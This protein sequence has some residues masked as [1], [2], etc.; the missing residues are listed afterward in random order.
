MPIDSFFPTNV[1]EAMK[2]LSR[3]ISLALGC[4]ALSLWSACET[5]PTTADAPT[6]QASSQDNER[7]VVTG[8]RL[9]RANCRDSGV[10]AISR[11]T[12]ERTMSDRA[13]NPPALPGGK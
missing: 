1:L 8:S 12:W 11:E 13:S 7:C 5:T 6:D 2:T 3:R 4:I 9:P 10:G